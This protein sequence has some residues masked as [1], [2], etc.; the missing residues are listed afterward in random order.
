VFQ[1]LMHQSAVP[2]PVAKRPC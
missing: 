2:P 1:N